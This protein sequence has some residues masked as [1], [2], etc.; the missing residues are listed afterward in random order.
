MRKVWK[1]AYDVSRNFFYEEEVHGTIDHR[2]EPGVWTGRGV[3][4]EKEENG[5]DKGIGQEDTKRAGIQH[6]KKRKAITKKAGIP[7][8]FVFGSPIS[9]SEA[10]EAVVITAAA[11]DE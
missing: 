11:Q 4:A 7:A 1:Y 2:W 5:A 9:R 8:F 3:S 10:S 6:A